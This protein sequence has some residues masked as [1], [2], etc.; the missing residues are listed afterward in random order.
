MLLAIL[1]TACCCLGFLV[2]LYFKEW[3]EVRRFKRDFDG[4]LSC[5]CSDCEQELQDSYMDTLN[6]G[7]GY[8]YDEV[9][10]I[11][12][13]EKSVTHV[14]LLKLVCSTMVDNVKNV[15]PTDAFLDSYCLEMFDKN[16][17]GVGSIF[18]GIEHKFQMREGELYP[19][20][21]LSKIQG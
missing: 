8:S 16:K 12:A 15:E 14:K 5:T 21:V 20:S 19:I 10:R 4:D 7:V 6:S 18:L 9:I 2:G 13:S 11:I 3:W 17:K 1:F